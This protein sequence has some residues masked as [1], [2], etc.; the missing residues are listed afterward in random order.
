[1]I[2]M[3]KI[4]FRL[5]EEIDEMCGKHGLTYYLG[6]VT[7]ATAMIHNGYDRN[8]IC[9]DLMM[10]ID[11]LGRLL[12]LLE[13]ELPA[14]RSVEHMGN[15]KNFIGFQISYVDETTTYIQLNRGTDVSKYGAR[16]NIIPIRKKT[17]GFA[18]KVLRVLETGWESNGFR[19][20]KRINIKT[21]IAAGTVRAAML[22][23][24]GNVAKLLFKRFMKHYKNPTNEVVIK[25]PKKK[26]IL[27]PAS[28]FAESERIVFAGMEFPTPAQPEDFLQLYFGEY[29]REKFANR[30]V[31]HLD[32]VIL[33]AMSYH[34]FITKASQSGFDIQQYFKDYR[35]SIIKGV[36]LLPAMRHRSKA[37]LI[38]K[39]S[40]DR[41]RLYEEFQQK[42]EIIHNLYSHKNYEALK[43]VFAEH[44]RTTLFYLKK[45]LGFCVCEEFFEIQC[46]LFSHFG[47]QDLV[48]RLKKL[49][50]MEHYKPIV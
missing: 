20:T 6:P 3:Q 29:W 30:N 37:I 23:G 11:D 10:P 15:S 1:M 47:R 31:N 12:Q 39:R 44:E 28:H 9:P 35:M 5:L 13:Q 41:L 40:G 49:V 42:R 34:E 16:L 48:E 2:S 24:K 19:F 50:P 32:S 22:I 45:K 36:F 33:P 8:L 26:S 21:V 46:A 14:N 27:I 18:A 43:L 25:E 17:T 7:L 4:T 38:A